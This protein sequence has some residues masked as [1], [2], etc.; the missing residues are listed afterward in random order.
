MASRNMTADMLES[1]SA[2][3][4]RPFYAFEGAFHSSGSPSVMF[5]RLWTGIG[6]LDWSGKTWTGGGHML[7]I[8]PISESGQIRAIGFEVTISGLSAGNLSLALQSGRQGFPGALWLGTLDDSGNV[9]ADPYLLAAGFF[10]TFVIKVTGETMTITAKYES[11]LI[12]L[13][14]AR[15]RRYT[16]EDQQLDFPGDKGFEYVQRL[17]DGQ[18][19]MGGPAAAASPLALPSYGGD[20]ETN[21]YPGD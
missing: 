10:D 15:E 21:T 20:I 1:I 11:R 19:L 13:E 4:V 14:R 17:Q 5:L 16:H 7:D 3:L 9:T 8:S 2:G 6:S 12:D 18:F